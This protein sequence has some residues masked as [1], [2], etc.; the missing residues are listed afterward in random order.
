LK[1]NNVDQLIYHLI[2]Y[3]P[4]INQ[5]IYILDTIQY[6]DDEDL[7]V[8]QFEPES[9][10]RMAKARY[11]QLTDDKYI[12]HRGMNV[13]FKEN[14][15]GNDNY[16]HGRY[17]HQ[18]PID[19]D[20]LAKVEPLLLIVT[21]SIAHLTGY[22][23]VSKQYMIPADINTNSNIRPRIIYF[24]SNEKQHGI[25]KCIHLHNNMLSYVCNNHLHRNKDCLSVDAW[26]ANLR[27]NTPSKR[28][29]IFV[30]VHFLLGV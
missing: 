10:D 30:N 9:A 12:I 28:N 24:E 18:Q 15:R 4:M 26:D 20:V 17:I 3:L 27:N 2:I 6:T 1:Y 11:S 7:F 23:N 29:Y 13:Y 16:H 5:Q 8:S 22:F 25:E 14:I 21:G 19:P